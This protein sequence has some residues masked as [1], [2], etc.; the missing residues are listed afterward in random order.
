[1]ESTEAHSFA[2][3]GRFPNSPLPVLVY[4]AVASIAAERASHFERLFSAHSWPAAWRNGLYTQ[5]H[6]HSTAHEVLGVY[7]GWVKARLGGERGGLLTLQAGD[8]IVIP[9]GVAHCNE[10]QSRDFRVVGAYP[11]GTEMDMNYG[12]P[13]E[14]PAADRRIASVPLPDRDPVLG[15]SGPLLELWR[16]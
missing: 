2:D 3:D 8:V 11:R 5:H 4:R 9:A 12:Q 14:R 7:E 6:Y 16:D 1:M 13:R 10:G 15:S